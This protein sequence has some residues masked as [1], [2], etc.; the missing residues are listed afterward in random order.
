MDSEQIDASVTIQHHS[1]SL[2]HI[3]FVSLHA[4]PVLSGNRDIGFVGGAEVQQCHIARGLAARGYQISMLCLDY[5]QPA[6]VEIDGI[7][8]HRLFKHSAG[9]PV[10][11]FF[12][13]RLILLWRVMRQTNADIYYQRGADM[14]TGVVAA[15]CRRHGKQSIFAGASDA[16]FS[17]GNQLIRYSRDKWLFEYGF[18]RTR[19]IV[20]QNPTQRQLCWENYSRDSML[21][22]SCYPATTAQADPSGSILWVATIRKF[23]GPER[24]I[25]LA[26][27]LPDYRFTMIGGPGGNDAESQLYYESIRAQA[28]VVPNLDFVGFVHP[29]DVEQYFD[30]ARIFINTSDAEGFPNTFL[31][32]WARRIPTISLFDPGSV[33]DG[34][35]VCSVVPDINGIADVINALSHNHAHWR[36]TGERCYQYYMRKH[37]MNSVLDDYVQLCQNLLEKI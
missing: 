24:F 33:E 32:A 20:V 37:S 26:K 12:Y 13:P 8:V 11:R 25:E 3:C 34:Q 22:R 4:W 7:R 28:A 1:S 15:F 10:L 5:G 14:H 17:N 21:I 6:L 18:K 16:D 23:K 31:Q 36:E 29:L 35:A 9:L 19:A 30:H 27:L 2:P